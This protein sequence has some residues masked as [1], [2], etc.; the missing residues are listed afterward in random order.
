MDPG[1]ANNGPAASDDS[2]RR[3]CDQCR[4]RKRSCTSTG[5]GQRP[6]EPRQRVLISS[7]YERKIDQIEVRLGNIESLLR[8][9]SQRPVS[10]PGSN[11]QFPV[12]PA[13]F[14]GLDPA[15]ASTAAFDSSDDES[16]L[17]GDS[18]IA[19][20]TTFASDLLEH[21]VE[22]TSLNDVSPKMW[23]ALANLRQL[24]ELQS[25][26]SISHG[27]RFPL[28]QPIPKGGLGQLPMPPMDIVVNLLKRVRASPPGLFTFVC[29][30]IGISDFSNLCRMVYFPTDDFSDSTFIIVNVGLY[31]LFLEQHHLTV[32]NK[33]LKDEFASHLYT[34]RINLETALAN[35]SLFMSTKIETVQA[36]LMGTLYTIDV[37]RPSVAWH[38]NCAAAQIC[39]TAGFHR[40]DLST[41]NPEE[42]D[43][44]AI[45]FWYTYTT[46]KALAL[47]LG[48]APAIQD[49]EITIPRTF[50]FDGI[51]SLETKAVAGTWLNAATLQGQVYEQLFCPAALS[52]PPAVLA[53]RARLLAAKCRR[54][55]AESYQSREMALS[56]L[57]K[58]GASPLVDVHLK[59]DEVQL[60]STM[61]LIYRAVPAPEG[62]PTRFCQ[63]CIDTARKAC[64]AH[65]TCMD[66]VRKD[67]HARAIYVHWNLVLTPFAPFFVLF[68]YV[69]ETSSQE[70]LQLLKQFSASIEE[71]SDASETMQKLSRLCNIM[72]NVAALYVEAKSQQVEDQAMVPIGDE[73]DVYLSQLGLMP[74]MDSTMGNAGDPD[75]EFGENTQVN[76]MADWMSGSRNLLGLLEQDISQIGG[77]QWPPM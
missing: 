36:L 74:V 2:A 23:E 68:G 16:V 72:S 31:Y 70:D 18:V 33:P 1:H 11:I 62:S 66:L 53:E 21:A 55:E 15:S 28:Q 20:Q 77:V 12:T 49:W 32:D 22:R 63:E 25:R 56:S 75:A 19:Q 71:T 52:Q 43:T 17:G 35:M 27:P 37:C 13:A 61:T 69:I 10:T 46:D 7:Q 58:I 44:K 29:Y 73:F 67:P 8:D 42:A 59:G 57:E 6:K 9:L 47:R 38:L 51:L 40:R 26:Q 14:P 30:F 39:Q 4:T 41:R 34:S 50:S 76:Q 64:H 45:L 60:L 24:A 48:R 65:F 54:V 3:A 5:V